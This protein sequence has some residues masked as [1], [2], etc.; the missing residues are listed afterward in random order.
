M[1]HINHSPSPQKQPHPFE[2]L[3]KFEATNPHML[4]IHFLL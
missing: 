1:G 3:Y 2:N 4:Q